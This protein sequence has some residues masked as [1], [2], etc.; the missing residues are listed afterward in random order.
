MLQN[1]GGNQNTSAARKI[2]DI[3]NKQEKRQETGASSAI[4]QSTPGSDD[5]RKGR[6]PGQRGS[7]AGARRPIHMEN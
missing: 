4:R 1:S 5:S 3:L 2:N 7:S 6:S